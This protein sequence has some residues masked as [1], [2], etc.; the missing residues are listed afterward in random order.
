MRWSIEGCHRHSRTT[1]GIVTW[2]DA[3]GAGRRGDLIGVLCTNG[4]DSG[5]GHG[6][7]FH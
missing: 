3:R 4:L 7:L 1:V 2:L 6:Y 5:A